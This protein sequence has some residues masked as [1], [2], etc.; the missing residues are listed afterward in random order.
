ME[1][2]LRKSLNVEQLGTL[3]EE[4]HP[5]KLV[6]DQMRDH[7]VITDANANIIYANKAVERHTGFSQKEIVGRNPG[8]FWGGKM[9]REFYEKMW[10][11][12]KVEKEPFVGEVVNARKGDSEYWQELRIT[13]VLDEHGEIKFFIGVEPDIDA[14]KIAE[15]SREMFISVF[16]RRTQNSFAAMRK[17]LDWLLTNSHLNQKERG[18]LETVYKEQHNLSI[19]MDDLAKLVTST[20]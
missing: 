14:R 10:Y 3:A 17:T 5:L 7:V 20:I 6:F 8:D 1:T 15:E 4:I 12:I 16:E 11:R 19:L 13:P 2:T 18:R 9:S